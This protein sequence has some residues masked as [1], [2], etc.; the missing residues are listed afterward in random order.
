M[1]TSRQSFRNFTKPAK[2]FTAWVCG[3]CLLFSGSVASGDVNVSD[4][5]PL[6][7][8]VDSIS[9]DTQS[10]Y[11]NTRYLQSYLQ[12]LNQTQT[13]QSDYQ[14]KI[15]LSL[16]GQV[17][18]YPP[19]GYTPIATLLEEI[20]S[21]TRNAGNVVDVLAGNPWWA[22][23]S[24]FAVVNAAYTSAYP[25]ESPNLT[26]T[27]SFPQFMSLWSSSLTMPNN[28]TSTTYTRAQLDSGVWA[29]FFGK[30]RRRTS[31][32]AANPY[33]WFDWVADAMRSNWVIQAGSFASSYRTLTN[34]VEQAGFT[35]DHTVTNAA[36]P[37]HVNV[38]SETQSDTSAGQASAAAGG[39]VLSAKVEQLQ[40]MLDGQKDS[41]ITVIPEFDVGGI[42]VRRYEANMNT[43]I[44]QACH[45]VMVFLWYVI[46]FASLFNLAQT[47][48]AFYLNL[49]RNWTMSG[50]VLHGK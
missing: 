21:N 38:I 35:E 11:Q 34:D 36:L 49:G 27:Y 43:P 6:F 48:L 44:T 41:W 28:N 30:Y 9:S 46:L 15:L 20:A 12:T 31:F 13:T 18:G 17:D 26:Y 5:E 24:A 42:Y 22:T 50:G 25:N 8:D 45:S 10:I 37:Q 29:E 32:T 16:T 2:S 19:V 1:T 33:T 40:D 47:E 39:Q 7:S 14:R 3:L 23:N 4:L